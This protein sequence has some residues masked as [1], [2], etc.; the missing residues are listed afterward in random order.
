MDQF[1]DRERLKALKI[2]C[3]SYRPEI[4]ISDLKL[5]F[6]SKEEVRKWLKSMNAPLEKDMIPAKIAHVV[7]STHLLQLS[8]KGVD[9]KGQIH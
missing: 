5:G 8:S 3:M 4:C 9:I 6:S 1:V 2:M 7:F